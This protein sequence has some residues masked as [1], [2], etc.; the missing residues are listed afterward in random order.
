MTEIVP[1]ETLRV[2]IDA[3]DQEIVRLF[4]ARMEVAGKIADA[5]REINKPI[6]DESRENIVLD[7][8]A[9]RL[10]HQ[11]WREE[12]QAVYR[13]LMKQ[14]REIQKRRMAES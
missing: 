8:N 13:E 9:D 11:E 4:E 2:E 5:K 14:S 6:Y 1:L 10:A 12:L 3:I 7:K